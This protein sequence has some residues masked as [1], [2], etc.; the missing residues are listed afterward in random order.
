MLCTAL[1]P[2]RERRVV[3]GVSRQVVY[4]WSSTGGGVV[5]ESHSGGLEFELTTVGT[6]GNSKTRG[7]CIGL[8]FVSAVGVRTEKRRF[9]NDV[10]R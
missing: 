9:V 4:L 10:T 2:E 1:S 3:Y 5:D 7:G 8:L 6:Y